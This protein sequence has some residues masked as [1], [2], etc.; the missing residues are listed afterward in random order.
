MIRRVVI[1]ENFVV[2]PS[3]SVAIGHFVALR[4]SVRGITFLNRMGISLSEVL[5]RVSP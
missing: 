3:S 1:E 2:P 4:A 5:L